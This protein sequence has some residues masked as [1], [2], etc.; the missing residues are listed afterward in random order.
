MSSQELN[1]KIAHLFE[2]GDW[3]GARCVLEEQRQKDPSNHWVL[4]QL[5]VALYEQRRYREALRWFR[6]SLRIVDDCPL[7]LWNIAGALDALGKHTAAIRIYTRLLKS[8]VSY[9]DD[10]CWESQEWTE[11]LKADCVYRLAGC[12]EQLGKKTKSEQCY[13][14]YLNLLLAG[15]N[16]LY[17]AQDVVERIRKLHGRRNGNGA[18]LKRRKA[19][20]ATLQIAAAPSVK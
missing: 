7:T 17:P 14:Q 1:D 10:P 19:L 9:R 20:R 15:V 11:S 3:S 16:G 4:T 8:G 13:R 12:F 6:K 2:V 18:V 5:G